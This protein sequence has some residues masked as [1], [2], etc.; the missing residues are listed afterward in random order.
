MIAS[1][2]NHNTLARWKHDVITTIV[3]R[4][5]GSKWGNFVHISSVINWSPNRIVCL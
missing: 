5:G 1:T 4:V 3:V 2:N